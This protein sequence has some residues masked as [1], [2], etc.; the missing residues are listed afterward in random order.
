MHCVRFRFFATGHSYRDLKYEFRIGESTIAK[1]I[2][3]V[4]HFLWLRL[5]PQY[6]PVQT[7]E[8]WLE[9]ARKFENIWNFP[10]AL[11]AID[12]KHVWIRA[13]IHSGSEYFCYKE[14]FSVVLMAGADACYKF[15][16]IDV[17]VQGRFSDGYTFTQSAFG[18]NLRAGTLNLPEDQN[19]PGTQL[20]MPHVFVADAAF[21]LQKHFMRPY[22]ATYTK[23]TLEPRIFNYRLSR[24][25]QCIE[26]TFGILA[27]RFRIYKRPFETSV[28]H[29]NAIGKAT[30]VLHNFLRGNLTYEEDVADLDGADFEESVAQLTALSPDRRRATTAAFKNREYFSNYF[31][32][33]IG[34]VPWQM[35]A[36]KKGKY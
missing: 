34:S 35:D 24:A 30:C 18:R 2:P 5:Q 11:A 19:L 4:S 20:S 27:A 9:N 36:V 7:Q 12:G 29:V 13:P 1:I 10:N 23:Q 31:N 28:E 25:R 33:P 6:M 8:S 16:F 3:E 32:S 21:P 14:K 15:V 26:C 17:G 22:P